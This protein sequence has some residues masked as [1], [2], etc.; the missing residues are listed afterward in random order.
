MCEWFRAAG[1]EIVSRGSQRHR[2][3][4]VPIA[5]TASSGVS[6]SRVAGAAQADADDSAA[7][8]LV[9]ELAAERS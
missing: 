3:E 5:F 8:H 9:V 7:D 4:F 1:Y 2:P 6:G